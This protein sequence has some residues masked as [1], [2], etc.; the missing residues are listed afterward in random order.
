M[1][2]STSGASSQE[3]VESSPTGPAY[4][5]T[6]DMEDAHNSL[7]EEFKLLP[8]KIKLDWNVA[9]VPLAPAYPTNNGAPQCIPGNSQFIT[10]D[11]DDDYY[12]TESEITDKQRCALSQWGRDP[13]CDG[14]GCIVCFLTIQRAL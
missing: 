10:L 2:G 8:T 4:S 12:I 9:H 3:S 13:R 1:A 5:P 11:D 6:S 14:S 7:R